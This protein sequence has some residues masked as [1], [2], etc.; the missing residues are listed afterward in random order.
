MKLD[1]LQ[2]YKLSINIVERIRKFVVSWDYFLKDTI[3]KQSVRSSDSISANIAEGFGRYF[4]IENRQFCYYSRGSLFETKTWLKKAF[5]RNHIEE[6]NY[7]GLVS[8]L[9]TISVKL[10]NY[11][12]TIGKTATK[13]N[14]Q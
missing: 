4:Y 1:D 6:K 9:E 10:N 11:I 7:Q 5:N 13:N 3:G 8:D 2:V 14:N 12:K